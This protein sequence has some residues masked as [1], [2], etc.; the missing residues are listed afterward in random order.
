L[1]F[2]TPYADYVE[3]LRG[4]CSQAGAR[5]LAHYASEQSGKFHNKSDSSPLTAA[6]LAS[7]RILL[8]GLKPFSLPV[9]SEESD[10]A[11]RAQAQ[12]WHRYWLVDPL[13]GTRE[14]LER[15]GEFTINIALIEQRQAVLGV[16][17]LPLAREIY[18]G[19][20]GE[21]AWR[22]RWDDAQGNSAGNWQ[23][24][25]CRPLNL[26][27][28]TVVLSSRRH[29]GEKLA[30]CLQQLRAAVGEVERVYAGSALKFCQLAA[31]EADFYP[32][33]AP[34]SE[35][36]T[37]AGQAVLEGAGGGLFDLQGAPLRYNRGGSM[38]NPDFLAIADPTASVWSVLFDD[39]A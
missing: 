18:L 15:T 31:G 26:A 7:H 11:V 20:P 5:I 16:V 8:K 24:I 28:P 38:L 13:D 27:N 36:D 29:R 32:R 37:A 6:D 25:A 4:L 14:F 39:L 23:A 19:I 9:L 33:F 10:P 1:P 30:A 17:A 34:C 21:G 35:W 22:C 3:P 12:Q 2:A